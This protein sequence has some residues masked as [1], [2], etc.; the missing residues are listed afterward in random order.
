MGH[1]GRL[2]ICVA[3]PAFLEETWS[4]SRELQDRLACAQGPDWGTSRRKARAMPDPAV[5]IAGI[6]RPGKPEPV[7]IARSKT[8]V[9]ELSLLCADPA[10]R[11][12]VAIYA[13]G[14]HRKWYMPAGAAYEFFD[15]GVVIYPRGL[16]GGKQLTFVVGSEVYEGFHYGVRPTEFQICQSGYDPELERRGHPLP[17]HFH[18]IWMSDDSAVPS[19][20]HCSTEPFD[21][22]TTTVAIN[23]YRADPKRVIPRP[24]WRQFC[25]A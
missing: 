6:A 24:D 8:H 12:K 19:A 20:V 11:A 4:A 15:D 16:N 3:A 13:G 7:W 1:E 17:V 18:W 2:L 14:E 21:P 25:S 10:G 23:V 5:S 22:N 9:A